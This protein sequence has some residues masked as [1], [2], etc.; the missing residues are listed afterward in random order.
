ML[1]HTH[2]PFRCA[3]LKWYTRRLF[4]KHFRRIALR[5]E[6]GFE[7]RLRDPNGGPIIFY[8]NHQ[9]WWDGFF[10]V[11]LLWHY[12]FDYAIMM[13]EKNLQKF[14]FFQKVGVFGVD[15]ESSLG[16]GRGALYAIRWLQDAHGSQ[17]RR[18][19]VMFPHGRLIPEHEPMPSFQPGLGKIL[20]KVP[21]ALAWPLYTKIHYGKHQLPDVDL[22]LGK[23]LCSTQFEDEQQ[24]EKGL[25]EIYRKMPDYFEV[26]GSCKTTL[27]WEN[28]N[29]M[30][31]ET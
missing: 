27:I 4:S 3:L 8:G 14:R 28:R 24:L 31:G 5:G 7:E 6:R 15:L 2:S 26:N 22:F 21:D 16:R 12:G 18:A 25:G 19:L 10:Y 1:E 29:K 9:T 11:H 13:E 20:S 17:Q 23:P 30:R